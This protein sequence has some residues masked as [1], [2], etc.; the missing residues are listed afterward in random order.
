ML[1]INEQIKKYKAQ[2]T[3][4]NYHAA[5]MKAS[6]L[7]PIYE[8]ELIVSQTAQ[9]AFG[10]HRILRQRLQGE[11]I[12]AVAIQSK[13]NFCKAVVAAYLSNEKES[14]EIKAM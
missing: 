7:I 13:L 12:W 9:K 5:G 10:R 8:K 6:R 3:R 11:N 2:A 14:Q 4:L 1:G